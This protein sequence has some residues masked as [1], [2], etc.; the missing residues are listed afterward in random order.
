[1]RL[2]PIAFTLSIVVTGC[3]PS[4][5]PLAQQSAR[6]SARAIID[7]HLHAF[8]ADLLGAGTVDQSVGAIDFGFRAPASNQ[9]NLD[10]T[11]DAL[12]QHNI[13]RAVVSRSS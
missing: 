11:L 1:M 3:T 5:Q 7:V 6:S 10:A 8:P 9:A 2:L 4:S 13:V 12:R